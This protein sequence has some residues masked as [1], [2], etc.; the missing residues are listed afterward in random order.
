MRVSQPIKWSILSLG[1]LLSGFSVNELIAQPKAIEQ[2][3]EQQQIQFSRNRYEFN[4]DCIIPNAG[5]AVIDIYLDNNRYEIYA[6]GNSNQSLAYSQIT[7][8]SEAYFSMNS[9]GAIVNN[10]FVPEKYILSEDHYKFMVVHNSFKRELIFDYLNNLLKIKEHKGKNK[11]IKLDKNAIDPISAVLNLLQMNVKKGN[12]Y[13]I[14]RVYGEKLEDICARILSENPVVAE[15]EFP[16]KTLIKGRT[17]L[18]LK[19][20]KEGNIV[21]LQEAG[22]YI[23]FLKA[24]ATGKL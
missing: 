7:M 18:K 5:E 17:K 6:K 12:E 11:E 9:L 15:I 24:W 3:A 20:T 22:L 8:V 13:F 2:A 21:H 4:V 19:Y 16:N 1:L 10:R 14:G 23:P